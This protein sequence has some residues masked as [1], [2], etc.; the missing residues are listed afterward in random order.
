MALT[1]QSV[2]VNFS[3][4]LDSK[5]DPNQVPVGKF[6]AL[7]NSVFTKGGAL[8]KRNGFA[9]ITTLPNRLQTTLTTL[10]DNLVATGSNLYSYNADINQWTNQGLVQPVS[11]NTSPLSR[12]S[13]TQTSPDAYIAYNGLVCSAYMAN[14]TAYFQ[15]SDS[16]TSEQIVK[17]TAITTID[18]AISAAAAPR[19]FVLGNY[20]IVTYLA[21]VSSTPHIK[22]I[23]IP[24]TNPNAVLGATNISSVVRSLSAG[25]DATIVNNTLYICWA[26]SSS[27]VLAAQLSTSLVLS[28]AVTVSNTYSATVVSVVA[29]DY[30]P[31]AIKLWFVYYDSST[32]NGYVSVYDQTLSVVYLSS[33]TVISST[34]VNTVTAYASNGSATI[35]YEVQNTYASPYPVS[36]VE[37][38][39]VNSVTCTQGGTVGSPITILRSVGLASK[40]FYSSVGNSI[41]MLVA[42]G[43][44]NQPSS[45]NNSNQPTYLLIDSSGNIYM[46]LAYS[47]GGGYETTQVLPS[48]FVR[49]FPDDSE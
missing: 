10:N 37:T 38:D 36:G 46:R 48:L 20:F 43:D 17:T 13:S 31:A 32:T 2:P 35:F 12:T 3:Q 33:A 19:V 27:S 30:N 8:T 18:T 24:I 49:G 16:Q 14:S 44:I 42:Y 11:L 29:D 9:N 40:A 25:Y 41:Y 28:G 22:Y 1:K 5:T 26:S 39:Y 47:N 6:L 23:A 45:T 7:T 15:V 34:P 21:T 4:G